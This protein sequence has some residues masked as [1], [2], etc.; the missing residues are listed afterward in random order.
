MVSPCVLELVQKT[1]GQVPWPSEKN[2][3]FKNKKW[4]ELQIFKKRNR[5]EETQS[6]EK[7]RLNLFFLRVFLCIGDADFLFQREKQSFLC[8]LST[9]ESLWRSRWIF[10]FFFAQSKQRKRDFTSEIWASRKILFLCTVK[11]NGRKYSGFR[12]EKIKVFFSFW[13]SCGN[14]LSF[15][16]LQK[17]QSVFSMH[18][19]WRF[20]KLSKFPQEHHC[21]FFWECLISFFLL[22]KNHL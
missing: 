4:R 5:T 21:R 8:F 11:N 18:S 3:T 2:Q 19:F 10:L 15:T 17:I 20:L 1:L 7:K 22:R 9:F 16:K 13:C 14:L 12:A 6:A